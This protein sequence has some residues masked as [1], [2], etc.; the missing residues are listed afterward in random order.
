[1]T[2]DPSQ[3]LFI[4]CLDYPFSICLKLTKEQYQENQ[5]LKKDVYKQIN[6]KIRLIQIHAKWTGFI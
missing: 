6:Y 2:L 1:M 5:R 3:I 4:V